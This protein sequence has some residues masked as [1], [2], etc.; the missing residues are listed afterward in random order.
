MLNLDLHFLF[1]KLKIR[2][3][4]ALA[5]KRLCPMSMRIEECAEV[6]SQHSYGPRVLVSRDYHIIS[7]N[8]SLSLEAVW[9]AG[10]VSPARVRTLIR[11]TLI[12]EPRNLEIETGSG[13]NPEPRALLIYHQPLHCFLT[14][15]AKAIKIIANWAFK[16]SKYM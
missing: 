8:C 11:P 14:K 3:P 7:I 2:Q 9:G 16:H 6:S 10:R 5:K 4:L 15:C 12:T 1:E 13:T